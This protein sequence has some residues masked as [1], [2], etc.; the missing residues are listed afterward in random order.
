MIN[1]AVNEKGKAALIWVGLYQT[2][3]LMQLI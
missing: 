1:S 3:T 2:Q